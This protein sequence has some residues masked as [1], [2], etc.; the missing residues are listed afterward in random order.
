MRLVI[1]ATFESYL[2]P[3]D[4]STRRDPVYHLLKPMYTAGRHSRYMCLS[5]HEATCGLAV[6][7]TKHGGAFAQEVSSL[8]RGSGGS[9]TKLL[10]VVQQMAQIVRRQES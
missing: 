7:K 2:C 5:N 4:R 10:Q 6:G 1:I 3:I 9:D 8:A